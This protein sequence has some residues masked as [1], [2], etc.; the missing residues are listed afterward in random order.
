MTINQSRRDQFACGDYSPTSGI[1]TFDLRTWSNGEDATVLN[2][3][4]SVF[5][6]LSRRVH[7]DDRSAQD[8]DIR[9][10]DWRSTDN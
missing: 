1:S 9:S 7:G 10:I 3:N 6:Y 4:A 5:N 8:E 2:R